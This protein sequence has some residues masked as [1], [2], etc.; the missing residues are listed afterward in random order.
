M[1]SVMNDALA[2]NETWNLNLGR[3]PL[4]FTARPINMAVN[5][6]IK[7]IP[8]LKVQEYNKD[9]WN[10]KQ[11]SD[12]YIE[13]RYTGFTTVSSY[14]DWYN[15]KT[16]KIIPTEGLVLPVPLVERFSENLSIVD[17]SSTGSQIIYNYSPNSLNVS[18]GW[19][20]ISGNTSAR[21]F[22]Y[23]LIITGKWK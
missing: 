13:M 19:S 20:I 18:C 8:E 17:G 23:S 4:G 15:F 5:Y 1:S 10:V 22:H 12:G 6:F 21:D 14:G 3:Q 11:Y 16:G 2:V 7:A 9:G